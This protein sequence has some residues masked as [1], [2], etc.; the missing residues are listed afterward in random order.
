MKKHILSR[1]S[2]KKNDGIVQFQVPERTLETRTIESS[3][4]DEFELE[5]ANIIKTVEN[6]KSDRLSLEPTVLTES[7]ENSDPDE[8][9]ASEIVNCYDGDFDSILLI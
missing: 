8:F 3:D 1:Y 6:L 7:I 4:P 2:E 5:P 9:L